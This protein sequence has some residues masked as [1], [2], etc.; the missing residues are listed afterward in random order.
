MQQKN[1]YRASNCYENL[2][3]TKPENKAMAFGI[4][5]QFELS[6]NC[7]CVPAFI[8]ISYYN[9]N[10]VPFELFLLVC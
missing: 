2:S 6:S 9:I 5:F 1:M 8:K 7:K 4:W 10:N 3:I